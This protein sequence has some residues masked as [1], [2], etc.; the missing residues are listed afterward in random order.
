MPGRIV[1]R[2]VDLDGK[3]GFT[4]TLQAREQHIRRGKATSNICTNQ[5]LLVT[6]ATIYMTLVGPQGLARVAAAMPCAHAASSWLRSR[7]SRACARRF[8]RPTLPRGRSDRSIVPSARCSSSSPRA[9]SSAASI[10]ARHYPELGNALLV[11]ATETK[12]APTSSATPPRSAARQRGARG[13]RDT[14]VNTPREKIIFE[15]SR[16]GRAATRPAAGGRAGRC[17]ARNDSCAPA[18]RRSS[19]AAGSLRAAG[20]AP[21]HASLA[22]QLLDRHALLSARLV[23]DEVQPARPVTAS[24]CC[25]SSSRAIRSRRNRT[26][27]ASSRAC[28]SCRKC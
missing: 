13:L 24:R 10:S 15:H 5:G 27:R 3:P 22:A 6:A 19:G 11:C 20:R 18:A 8:S 1:G 21:L 14:N 4:L 26:G 9:A 16:P 17:E 23:H 28:T 7:A 2:T 25:P 12:N